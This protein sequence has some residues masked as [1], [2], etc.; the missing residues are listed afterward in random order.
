MK[1]SGGSDILAGADIVIGC[2]ALALVAIV[3]GAFAIGA[4]LF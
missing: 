2:F 3:A 1:G 4:W